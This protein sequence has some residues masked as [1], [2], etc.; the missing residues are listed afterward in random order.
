MLVVFLEEDL[1]GLLCPSF[2]LKVIHS[3]AVT[4]TGA[5]SRSKGSRALVPRTYQDLWVRIVDE[6]K[7]V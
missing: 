5:A 4:P 6:A 1:G 7:A 2:G 3:L